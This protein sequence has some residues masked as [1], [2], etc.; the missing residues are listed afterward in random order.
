MPSLLNT[1]YT[2]CTHHNVCKLCNTETNE[3]TSFSQEV[4]VREL[5]VDDPLWV[6]ESM[7]RVEE[8][9]VA[10]LAALRFAAKASCA[11]TCVDNLCK[12][13]FTI[14]CG[15]CEVVFCVSVKSFAFCCKLRK[16]GDSH[17][18]MSSC[19]GAMVQ[20]NAL[21]FKYTLD[22]QKYFLKQI[23]HSK[24]RVPR[25]CWNQ[26]TRNI[27]SQCQLIVKH[28]YANFKT[29]M[30][31]HT[32][33]HIRVRWN[34]VPPTK[35]AQWS[36]LSGSSFSHEQAQE[37]RDILNG[38]FVLIGTCIWLRTFRGSLQGE[39]GVVRTL[40]HLVKYYLFL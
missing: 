14:Q 24:S 23:I 2:E 28:W 6:T 35:L 20:Y 1:I 21:H 11:V 34:Y 18:L 29:Y 7:R 4:S 25:T 37:R 5:I 9:M 15:R 39:F 27:E 17:K 22:K 33:N 12:L 38:V 40:A 13:M 31:K 3:I 19:Y 8:A 30:S 36:T 16:W 32:F 10:V 26:N